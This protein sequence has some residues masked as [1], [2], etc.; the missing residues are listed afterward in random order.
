MKENLGLSYHEIGELLSRDER[1][2]WTSYK[3]AVGKQ[4]KSLEIGKTK[5]Y[6][7]MKIF[8]NKLTILESVVVYLKK[9]GLKYSE[10]AGLLKR[11]KS[12]I[13]TIYYRAAKKNDK[14]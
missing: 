9:E 10:I 12:N 4:S 7:P 6:L 5:I 8:N 14:I 1:N 3:K 13:W 2:I 11:D